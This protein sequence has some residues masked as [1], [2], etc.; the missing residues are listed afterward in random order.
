MKHVV[1]DLKPLH[2][3]QNICVHAHLTEVVDQVILHMDNPRQCLLHRI[4]MDPKGQIL[5]SGNAVVALLILIGQHLVVFLPEI[6]EPV[7]CRLDPDPLQEPFLIGYRI[8][9]RQFKMDRTVEEVE[10]R[11][12]VLQDALL[13]PEGC[14]L[15]VDVLKCYGFR[16]IAFPDPADPVLPHPVKRYGLLDRFRQRFSGFILSHFASSPSFYHPQSASSDLLF[17]P[18]LPCGRYSVYGRS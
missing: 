18:H 15:V 11:T 13:V 6:I 5:R 3:V 9:K 14:E 12:P 2:A 16:V 10:E 7:I 1:H 8:D 17:S 4:R